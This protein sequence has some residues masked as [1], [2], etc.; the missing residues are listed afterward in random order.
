M[1]QYDITALMESS[2]E[3]TLRPAVNDGGAMPGV[4]EIGTNPRLGPFTRDRGLVGFWRFE[5][6]TG[7]TTADSSGNANTGTLLHGPT[8]QPPANCKQGRCLSFDGVDDFVVLPGATSIATRNNNITVKAWAFSRP[9]AQESIHRA[10]V[11]EIHPPNVD[12]TIFLQGAGHRLS[13]GFHDGAWHLISG[14]AFPMDRWV[15]VAATYDGRFIRLF[16][17]GEQ[18]TVS[19]DLNRLLPSGAEGWRIGR[20][21]DSGG[22]SDMWNGLIDEVRI[23]NRALSAS[24]IAAIYAATK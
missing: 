1:N 4:L 13:A 17:N 5:E 3:P 20:R 2:H 15:H 7:T 8:W 11:S 16:M 19:P 22:P 14:S 23:Y 21:H 10:I 12:F 9:L 6:G 18:V 24:E